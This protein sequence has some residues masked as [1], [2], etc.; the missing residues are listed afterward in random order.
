MTV[1]KRHVMTLVNRGVTVHLMNAFPKPFFVKG[2][3][4][5]SDPNMTPVDDSV[6]LIHSFNTASASPGPRLSAR[7]HGK[8]LPVSRRQSFP[9]AGSPTRDFSNPS[10]LI[11]IHDT[12]R[13]YCQDAPKEDKRMLGLGKVPRRD[14][15][16]MI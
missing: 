12:R 16:C 10:K 7:V 8:Y 4:P 13:L 3:C 9:S 14:Q 6:A 1:M 15:G 5:G 11:R 2:V